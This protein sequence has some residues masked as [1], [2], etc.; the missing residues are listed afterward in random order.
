MR[1]RNVAVFVL[2]FFGPWTLSVHSQGV[3][4]TI[5]GKVRN[6]AGLNMSQLTVTLESG[7]GGVINQVV[8]NNEGDFV[9][10][11]LGDSSYVVIVNAP[12][13][14][15]ASER[16]DFVRKVSPN[17]PGETRTLEITLVRKLGTVPPRGG[18]NFVQDI[19]KAAQDSFD[20][21]VKLLKEGRTDASIDAL[22]QAIK[23][24]P[25]YFNARLLLATQLVAEQ[26]LDE[27][28][29]QL[30]EARRI[31]PQDDRVYEQFGMILMQ[32]HK[33]AV[34]ARVFAEASNLNPRETKYLLLQGTALIN[35]ASLVQ[36][37]DVR[38]EKT[39]A[40][41]EAEKILARAY[42]LS[43]KK[44]STVHLQLARIYEK[45]GN[46][47]H[48]AEE[49]EAYLRQVPGDPKAAEL[50]EAINKLRTP[51]NQP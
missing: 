21:A 34:A 36:G 25:N 1:S 15:P 24:Y 41:D 43:G 17:D 40:L 50:R 12:D 48:A 11:G 33:Y 26:H 39:Y 49:L 10:S 38:G 19:P 16:I 37:S 28:I 22:K 42:Q 46:K 7:N 9:F 31:N 23:L 35:Q 51:A 20:S 29:T 18:V 3:G 2:L 47:K 27:A 6:S 44:L 4:H 5:R 8:T 45:R 13:Y 14:N 32:Q 30:E